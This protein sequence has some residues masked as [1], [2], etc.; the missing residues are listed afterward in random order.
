VV[1]PEPVNKPSSEWSWRVFLHCGVLYDAMGKPLAGNVD[2]EALKEL[3][4]ARSGDSNCW[5]RP[6]GPS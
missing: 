2:P 1:V 4:Y 6:N 5:E 3:G